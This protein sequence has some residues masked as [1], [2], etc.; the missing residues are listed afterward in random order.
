MQLHSQAEEVFPAVCDLLQGALKT[1][2]PLPDRLKTLLGDKLYQRIKAKLGDG[3]RHNTV[4]LTFTI[5][6]VKLW[7][8]NSDW[9]LVIAFVR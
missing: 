5:R 1:G 8:D 2:E 3:S 6:A 9:V 7:H 4:K